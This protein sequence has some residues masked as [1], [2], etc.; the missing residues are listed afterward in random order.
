MYCGKN[1][2]FVNEEPFRF[3]ENQHGFGI[4]S[5]PESS[6][7]AP[8]MVVLNAGLLHRSEPYRLNTLICREL[9]EAGYICA[10]VDLAGKGDSP[11]RE[12]MVNR[13]SVAL[14]WHHIKQALT[15]H[16]GERKFI[17]L[18]LCSGADN[19]IK[20]C[21]G[22]SSVCGM[23]LLDPISL[24]DSISVWRQMFHHFVNPRKLI[25]LPRSVTGWIAGLF[26]GTHRQAA[27]RSTLRDLPTKEDTENCF[28]GLLQRN[29]KVLAV[30][31]SYAY[32][33]YNQV[34]QFSRTL[35]MEGLAGICE[36]VFWPTVLH[37]YP[38][39]S[40]RDQLISLIREWSR[41]NLDGFRQSGM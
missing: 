15:R 38:I 41:R 14:D 39:Q 23:V 29:G 5:L 21:A 9:A 37:L 10:R 12:S 11:A 32:P 7:D 19:A 28:R 3:G 33:Q 1:T 25:G 2:K 20:L 24:H 22:D 30:F 13:E 16:L 26:G 36:E 40:H 31:T 18:G 8:V 17:L 34:G 35:N 4:L 6:D 27:D